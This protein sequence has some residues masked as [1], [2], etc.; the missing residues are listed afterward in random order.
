MALHCLNFENVG[1][2]YESAQVRCALV[3]VS[4]DRRFLEQVTKT[5]WQLEVA[6]NRTYC[7]STD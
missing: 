1:F 6:G 2:G 4:H 3:L 5:A 7:R